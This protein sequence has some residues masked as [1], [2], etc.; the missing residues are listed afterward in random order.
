MYS[1]DN[2]YWAQSFSV[3]AL[4]ATVPLEKTQQEWHSHCAEFLAQALEGGKKWIVYETIVGQQ[5]ASLCAA[6]T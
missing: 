1:N 4:M 6:Q 5:Q 3:L 2:S